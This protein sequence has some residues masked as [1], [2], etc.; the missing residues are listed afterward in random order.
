MRIIQ[1]LPVLAFGDAIGNDTLTLDDTLRNNGYET[2]I[3]AEF[4]DERLGKAAETID[5]YI[6]SA[7]DIILFHL[8]TGADMNYKISEYP[9]KISHRDISLKDTTRDR[10]RCVTAEDARR[11]ISEK[12][13]CFVLR[14]RS[15]INRN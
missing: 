14:T 8:S 11:S 2:A 4:V 9:G 15:S 12:R 13:H 1:M 3:Y 5:K 10:L 6:P 7:D